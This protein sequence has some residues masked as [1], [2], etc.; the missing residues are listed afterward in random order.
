MSRLCCWMQY[1]VQTK[2]NGVSHVGNQ[3]R[4]TY[5][6]N[7]HV[8][9]FETSFRCGL[10]Q[11]PALLTC[12]VTMTAFGLGEVRVYLCQLDYDQFLVRHRALLDRQDESARAQARFE[13]AQQAIVTAALQHYGGTLPRR[14]QLWSAHRTAQERYGKSR[15]AYR[16]ADDANPEERHVRLKVLHRAGVCLAL[17]MCIEARAQQEQTCDTAVMGTL[18]RLT[19]A[20]LSPGG[21]TIRGKEITRDEVVAAALAIMRYRAARA[22]DEVAELGAVEAALQALGREQFS[23]GGHVVRC[24]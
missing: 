21:L 14:D 15:V 5:V 12:M 1:T 16:Y 19:M 17:A 4:Q 9:G 22:E 2:R 10:C 23:E 8:D 18:D 13:Q 7:G 3:S 24:G 11:A 20:F 6:G